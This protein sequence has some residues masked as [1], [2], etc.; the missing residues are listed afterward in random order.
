[1][2]TKDVHLE[3]ERM[4]MFNSIIAKMSSADYHSGGLFEC[5][6]LGV[7]RIWNS[8]HRLEYHWYDLIDA[9]SFLKEEVQ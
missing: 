8:K 6:R 1:M 7:I 9:E 4:D 2:N 5:G 3:I